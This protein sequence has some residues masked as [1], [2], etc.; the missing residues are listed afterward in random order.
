MFVAK[1]S[2]AGSGHIVPTPNTSQVRVRG[3]SSL[4]GG[5]YLVTSP[6]VLTAV[7]SAPVRQ[8]LL[9]LIALCLTARQAGRPSLLGTGSA[10]MG[11][12]VRRGRARLGRREGRVACRKR[13]KSYSEVATIPTVAILSP[14]PPRSALASA[15]A[16][17]PIG[18]PAWAEAEYGTVAP[19]PRRRGGPGRR[20]APAR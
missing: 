16:R 11:S 9:A 2:L 7:E 5:I 4:E 12:W 13:R 14:A 8:S 17:S 19:V 6:D 15:S 20:A 3:Q 10:T 1:H 18:R